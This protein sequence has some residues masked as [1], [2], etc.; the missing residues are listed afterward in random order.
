M[1]PL[2]NPSEFVMLRAA[3]EAAAGKSEKIRITHLFLGLLKL[4]EMP[5]EPLFGGEEERKSTKYEIEQ[6]A[7]LFRARNI[8]T[9]PARVLIRRIMF[10]MGNPPDSDGETDYAEPVA[11]LLSNASDRAAQE[12]LAAVPAYILLR[13]IFERPPQII[14]GLLRERNGEPPASP[15]PKTR[16]SMPGREFLPELTARVR[17]M[18]CALLGAIFGQDHA[19]HTFSE[20]LFCSELLAHA[21]E[22]R[23][24]PRAIFVFAGPPGIGKTFLAEQ[25]A[26][27]LKIPFRRFD[28]SS[29]SD[30]QQHM[31][32]IGWAPSY[33]DAKEGVLTGF[34]RKNPHCILLFDE[35]EKA[36]LNCIHLFLQILDAGIL[37]DKFREENAAFRDTIIIFTTN[38]G[39]QLYEGDNRGNCAGIPRE[40]ILNAL[41]TDVRPQTGEPF[42][43]PA[44]CSRLATGWPIMFNH[45]QAQD[46]EKISDGEF[47]RCAELFRKQYGITVE[48]DE[49]LPIALLFREGGGNDARTLRAQT[50]I[51][52]KNEIYQLC[53]LFHTDVF[54]KVVTGLDAIRFTVE[55]ENLPGEVAPIFH[56]SGKPEILLFAS[57]KS[58]D[59][60]SEAMP[61]YVWRHTF[62]S[63]EAFRVL[64]EHDIRLVLFQPAVMSE[65]ALVEGTLFAFDNIPLG[66]SS[67][68]AG[69]NFFRNLR[70][71]MPE[72][73]VY[74][75]ETA[76]FRIDEE[77]EIAFIRGGARGKLIMPDREFG[78]FEEELERICRRLH[79]QQVAATLAAEQKALRFETAPKLDSAKRNVTVRIRGFSLKRVLSAVDTNEVLDEVEK[80]ETRFE[81]VIGADG[82][83]EELKFFIDYLKNPGKFAALGL[84]PPKG[85]L[86]YGPP[87]TGK[88]MLARAM[89][90]ESDVAFIPVAASSFVT[91]WQGSGPE[92]VKKLFRCARRYAPAIVF[93]DE[94]DAVGRVRGGGNGG[95]E[96][97]MALNA[98]LTEMDGFSVDPKRPVFVLAATNFEMEESRPGMGRIDPALAR[99]FDRR[100]L[101][102]LPE[103]NARMKYLELK[104]G[105]RES[106]AA[107][108]QM[109]DRLAGRS[110]GMSLADLESVI[111]LAARTAAKKS[112]PLTDAVLEEA[113]ELTRHGEA[114]NWGAVCLERVARHE[115]GHAYMDWR[116]GNTPAYLT[117]VARG[118][119]GGYM[120]H[121]DA[122][123]SPPLKTRDQLLGDLRTALGGRAAEIV[124]YGEKNGLSTGASGDL[125]S[126]TRLARA[127]ICSYGMD[128]EFGLAAI[129]AEDSARGPLAAKI[130]ERISAMIKA[131]MAETVAILSQARTP[132]D[133]L[134]E[135]LLEKNRLTGE[136]IDEILEKPDIAP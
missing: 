85:V 112:S 31:D 100:I 36:H 104:L 98:L 9:G 20:G 6:V 126:A 33:K 56:S 45:L 61:G 14:A 132:L 42:F 88:T 49:L 34:V 82:A 54:E 73:P 3:A 19:V 87:G 67:L 68:Q 108:P 92:S 128:E 103:K 77:L 81:D 62:D 66:A 53:R 99:R 75:L 123:S 121:A 105:R 50:E 46:L 25:A 83:K 41:E 18:R 107:T 70:T 86:L 37:E 124:C 74:L 10:D 102:D 11:A 110:A 28:M 39:R 65:S 90:G 97:E 27:F 118:G 115:A 127:M 135:K 78:V 72:M 125:E 17:D 58:A 95:H 109:L 23:K 76:E 111:E 120:E 16:D 89:A 40:T 130:N 7:E 29:Y 79:L 44:I 52:F 35:I 84:K 1:L 24:R 5:S 60:C 59:R 47:K 113:F 134:V 22:K 8:G 131:E 13:L 136:E 57:G 91:K 106:C 94:I 93:I 122:E 38:A 48:A 51:F 116:T 119:H 129:S 55:L 133:R 26:G 117:I 12:N 64:A 101:V 2:S 71:R 43:P 4:A 21:D 114:K 69:R 80:P 15:K 63:G 30:P 32:L 96:E